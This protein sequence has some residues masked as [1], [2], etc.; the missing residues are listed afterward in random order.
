MLLTIFEHAVHWA[1]FCPT[2][3]RLL[4]WVRKPLIWCGIRPNGVGVLSNGE[5]EASA[6]ELILLYI[7][8]NYYY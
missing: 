2:T 4:K 3:K 8:F 7:L 1:N 6:L 5:V